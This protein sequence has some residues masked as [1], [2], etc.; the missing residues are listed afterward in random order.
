MS[1]SRTAAA[2]GAV[3][4]YG[5][6]LSWAAAILLG[7]ML[8]RTDPVLA[9][10]VQLGHPFDYN[11][12]RFSLT[13]EAGLNDGTAFPF[14]MLGLGPMWLHDIGEPGIR[15][16]FADVRWAIAGSF[17]I[18]ALLGTG[19]ARIVLYLRRLYVGRPTA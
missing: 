3:G 18:G 15:W 6:G 9:N 16:L 7:A 1:C 13:A 5:I 8:A 11:P 2:I 17:L 19:V 12:L 14:I 10:D 4:V